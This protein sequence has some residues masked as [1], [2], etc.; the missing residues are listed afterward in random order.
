[1]REETRPLKVSVEKINCI[2]WNSLPLEM[3]KVRK[4]TSHAKAMSL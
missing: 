3:E 4:S 2:G 1:M